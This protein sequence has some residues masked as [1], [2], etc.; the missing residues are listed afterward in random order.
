MLALQDRWAEELLLV[1]HEMTWMVQ[2][3]IHKSQQWVGRMQ[4]ANANKMVGHHC[5]AVHQAQ[6][7]L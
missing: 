6:I 3:F 1:G 5:Y 7:Y 2:F 4:E